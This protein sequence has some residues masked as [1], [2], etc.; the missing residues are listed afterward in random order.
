MRE[1]VKWDKLKKG[2]NPFIIEDLLKAREINKA[3]G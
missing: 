2:I 3:R 1:L